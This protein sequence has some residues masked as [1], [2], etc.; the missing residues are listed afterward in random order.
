MVREVPSPMSA[1]F[2]FP[3]V[4]VILF[5]R[6]GLL[7]RHTAARVIGKRTMITVF[8]QS[9]LFA[10]ASFPTMPSML[11]ASR[12]WPTYFWFLE[13]QATSACRR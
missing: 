12:R 3:T 1:L 8:R 13:S 7:A 6:Q 4:L 11:V 2:V 10:R 9:P 5:S